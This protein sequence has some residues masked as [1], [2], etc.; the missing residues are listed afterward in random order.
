[1]P[2]ALTPIYVYIGAFSTD[3]DM[4][5]LKVAAGELG[6]PTHDNHNLDTFDH[7]MPEA[8]TSPRSVD[9]ICRY[10]LAPG[11]HTKMSAP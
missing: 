7:A 3:H 8:I 11:T 1:M 9:I 4:H 6:Q 10:G 5:F 2:Y